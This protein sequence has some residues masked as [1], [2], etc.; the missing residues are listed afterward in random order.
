M[1]MFLTEA[2][3]KLIGQHGGGG[4][5][6]VNVVQL[7]SPTALQLSRDLLKDKGIAGLYTGLGATLL[8]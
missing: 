1:I 3:R 4:G 6:K 5:A 8:R 2:Q 7:K